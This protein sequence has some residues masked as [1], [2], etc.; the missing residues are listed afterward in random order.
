MLDIFNALSPFFKN[1]AERINVR[2][3]ARRLK[4]SPPTASTTLKSFAKQGL[5][6]EERERIYVFY[7]A[8][9]RSFLFIELSRSYWRQEFER[10]GL[11]KF[12]EEEYFVPTIILFGS[13][14]DRKSTRLNS[15][16]IPLS[17]MPSSA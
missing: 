2:E 15:S 10:V 7:R 16:H 6:I 13:L 14:R 11:L 3:Y 17:R 4:I 9:Q 5:L 1:C 8:N 12:L